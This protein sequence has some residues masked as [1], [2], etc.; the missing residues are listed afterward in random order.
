MNLEQQ[1][2]AALNSTTTSPAFAIFS[3][4]PLAVKKYWADSRQSIEKELASFDL[5]QLERII[6]T[7]QRMVS[8][9]EIEWSIKERQA[10]AIQK[11]RQFYAEEMQDEMTW[12]E[13]L[14]LMF[15]VKHNGA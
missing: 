9:R 7:A 10:I 4:Q 2:T 8:A 12:G 1:L 13:F 14:G 3:G 15:H 5:A 6:F 11:A